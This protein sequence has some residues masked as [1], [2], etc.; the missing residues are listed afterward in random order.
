MARKFGGRKGDL[1]EHA[2]EICVSAR[3]MAGSR[4][5]NRRGGRCGWRWRTGSEDSTLSSPSR[6]RSGVH[7]LEANNDSKSYLDVV[8]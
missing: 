4:T 5:R 6:E 3:E 1:Y 2:Q 7:R 8:S